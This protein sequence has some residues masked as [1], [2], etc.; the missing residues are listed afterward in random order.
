MVE[1][2]SQKPQK[3]EC[4]LH[5]F[6]SGFR[7][8]QQEYP[9]PEVVSRDSNIETKKIQSQDNYETTSSV[10]SE[11]LTIESAYPNMEAHSSKGK[12]ITHSG[13]NSSGFLNPNSSAKCIRKAD[14]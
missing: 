7:K 12:S 6:R 13:A 9:R 4:C 3:R 5:F 1:R 11:N 14:N 10:G 2:N 8:H